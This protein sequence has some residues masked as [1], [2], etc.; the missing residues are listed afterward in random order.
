MFGGNKREKIIVMTTMT[1]TI[2]LMLLSAVAYADDTALMQMSEDAPPAATKPPTE[3]QISN[4]KAQLLIA[5][6]QVCILEDARY[7]FLQQIAKEK[8]YA[9]IG[10]AVSLR[11]LYDLQGKI[12]AIDEKVAEIKKAS[13]DAKRPV[14]ACSSKTM[15]TVMLC[16]WT[17]PPKVCLEEPGNT[18]VQLAYTGIEDV[19]I[20]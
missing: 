18:S 11:T 1:K 9:R 7:G 20:E 6:I 8:K 13:V 3:E 10:G 19:E 16:A 17:D 15:K 5:S 14:Y 4:K 2:A 12:R